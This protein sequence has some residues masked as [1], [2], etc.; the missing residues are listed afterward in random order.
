MNYGYSQSFSGGFGRYSQP[1][2]MYQAPTIAGPSGPSGLQRY[3]QGLD[4]QYGQIQFL[5]E[6]GYSDDEIKK[7]GLNPEM[8]RGML[9]A[10]GGLLN[11]G[12]EMKQ[13]LQQDM[14]SGIEKGGQYL[15][16][17]VASGAKWL[18]GAL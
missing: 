14:I 2:P 9:G 18:G 12:E 8:G 3:A 6:Q 4:E 15:G 5:K 11:R 13:Q 16:K 17:Q 7:L 10:Y 1:Q